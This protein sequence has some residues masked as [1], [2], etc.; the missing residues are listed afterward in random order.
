MSDHLK[1][2]PYYEMEPRTERVL[3]PHIVNNKINTDTQS[4]SKSL[5]TLFQ[6]NI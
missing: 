6:K 5:V 3:L 2:C 1:V 4:N